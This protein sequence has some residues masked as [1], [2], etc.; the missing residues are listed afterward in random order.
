MIAVP[1]CGRR[2][3]IG[4]LEAFSA[5]P[6]GFNESDIRNLSLM[7]ELVMG[8]LKPEDEDRFANAPLPEGGVPHV[9]PILRDRFCETDFA[10]HG[11]AHS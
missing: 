1:L 4:V 9:S 2:S 3:V 11:T 7:A 8:A 5:W 6:F 10:R